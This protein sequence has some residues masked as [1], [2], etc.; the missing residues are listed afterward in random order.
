MKNQFSKR[1]LCAA[2]SMALMGQSVGAVAMGAAEDEQAYGR[3]PWWSRNESTIETAT[4]A[5]TQSNSSISLHDG[6]A[7]IPDETNLEE[8]QSILAEALI[9]GYSEENS[10]IYDDLE[11]EYLCK[12]EE[13][14]THIWANEQWGSIAGFDSEKKWGLITTKYHH[15]A[16]A[17]N[18][19]EKFQVRIA[20][21]TDEVTLTKKS[22]LD[23]KIKLNEDVTVTIP[24]KNNG[25]TDFDALRQEIFDKV[26]ASTTPTMKAEN[27]DI[28]YKTNNHSGYVGKFV[29]LEGENP[30]IELIGYPAIS[31]GPHTIKISYDGKKGYSSTEETAEN[32]EF[33]ASSRTSGEI[34][35]KDA[36]YT[37]G[38]VYD[39]NNSI[40]YKAT[41]AAILNAVVAGTTPENIPVTVQYDAATSS[42]V[43]KQWKELSHTPGTL[44][45]ITKAF[46]IGTW[47]IR[48]SFPG[49]NEYTAAEEI[50]S[51]E[52][53]A[54]PEAPIVFNNGAE[55]IP[56]VSLKYT[57]S[58]DGTITAEVGALEQTIHSMFTTDAEDVDLSSATLE[59]YATAKT[60]SVGDLGKAWVPLNGGKISGLVYPAISEDTWQV[61][62][63]YPSN[64]TYAATTTEGTV[65]VTGREALTYT[66]KEAPYKVDM[67]FNA[68]QDYD[69]EATIHAIYDAVVAST[70]PAVDYDAV[71]MEYT[72]TMDALG[73]Y[74]KPLNHQGATGLLDFKEGTWKI[75]ITWPETVEYRATS[76]TVEVTVSDNRIAS[77]VVLKE[78][79]SF[80]YNMDSAVMKQAIF[81]NV[82]DWDASTLP[83][84][85]NISD[86]EIKY[87][88]QLD[89]MDSSFDADKLGSLIGK[90][91]GL[92]NV[93]GSIGDIAGGLN[94]STKQWMPIEGG[95]NAIGVPYAP[96]GAGEHQV[97]VTFKGNAEYKP[98]DAAEAS[99]TVNKANVK[100]KVRSDNI[101]AGEPLPEN[102][103]TTDPADKFDFYIVYAGATSDI[104]LGIYIDLPDQYDNNKFMK[105]LD[106]LVE[107][108]AGKSFTQMI[109]DGVTL[110]ELRA[111]F[112][113][114][115]F[116]D[117][118]EKIGVDTGA[119]GQIIKVA[120]ALPS[121]TD[122]VRVGFGIPNR[123]GL[124][125]VT[126][127]TDNKN[128]NTGVGVGA[129]LVRMHLKGVKLTWNQEL[130]SKIST[131]DAKNF[132]FKATLSKDG[133]VSISQSSVH[134]LYSGF[135]SKW[136]PYSS[137][138]TPPTEPGRYSMTVVTLGGNYQ[139]A[140]I[141]RTFQITK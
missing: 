53:T 77:A 75:R 32:I 9:D 74:F 7:V 33:I 48:L 108:I 65:T 8:V 90:I 13:T 71:E 12:G 128:Y 136:R 106:P 140:P 23:S 116:I 82:I 22:S 139:A 64:A 122:G 18:S 105:I 14:N 47:S 88:A 79:A 38:M 37:V 30:E 111:L 40:N 86:F 126:A 119:F 66:L 135:T 28:T 63:I 62:L 72:T 134:Y 97:Q 138:T 54:R 84:G 98:S 58:E 107:K 70:T 104:S 34:S 110:G 42:V 87:K 67:Q 127:I 21:T 96:M 20:G 94:D 133:D 61:R 117:L 130:G 44:D 91:P 56:K 15:P 19:G 73:G 29:P 101:R 141:T 52:M 112:V 76:A 17:N 26:V 99:V 120:S 4:M 49:T 131:A 69:Y 11:W 5:E 46:G 3:I 59:Y 109:Q 39:E 27:V 80:T 92:E 57:Q 123:A 41:E 121:V 2:L 25:T 50:V 124:Y 93:G 103:I 102:F 137:T 114:T 68:E 78:G 16:L 35:L 60:G 24:L 115:D 89:V 118:L 45:V 100:V 31:A 43:G 85:V 6:T 10:Q 83:D 95:K 55:T 81:D 1:L 36:P 113:N 125:T 51:V 129:L 132:D